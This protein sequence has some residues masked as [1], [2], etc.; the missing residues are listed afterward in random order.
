MKAKFSAPGEMV[1]LEQTLIVCDRSA[2]C[3][4]AIEGDYGSTCAGTGK[5][6]RKDGPKAETEWSWSETMWCSFAV[7][8]TW[9]TMATT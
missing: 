3:I 8:C 4:R 1:F 7:L 6:G 9:P 2:H 5:K